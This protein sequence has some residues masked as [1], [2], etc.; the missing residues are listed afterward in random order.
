M[1][2]RWI[3][4]LAS[5]FVVTSCF[6]YASVPV[7]SVPIGKEVRIS[8]TDSGYAHLRDSIGDQFPRLRKSV[9]GP[10]I[11]VDDLR[12]L[13]ALHVS[14][15]TSAGAE[16]QQRVAIPRADILGVERKILDRKKTSIIAAG[17]GVALGILVYQ[18]V[19]GEFGG[20]THPIPEPGPGENIQVRLRFSR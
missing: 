18:W 12:L 13:V 4:V 17:A 7:G 6:H 1:A 20:T 2:R 8:L 15:G 9:E 11:G 3:A 16:L 14:A 19:S 10:L 5:P